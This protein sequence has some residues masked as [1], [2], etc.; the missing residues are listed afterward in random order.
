GS[1]VLKT[2]D[3]NLES[4]LS[5]Y[6]D[7][8]Y[9]TIGLK[10]QVNAFIGSHMSIEVT[11]MNHHVSVSSNVVLERASNQVVTKE[12]IVD[13]ISKLGN[14]PFYFEELIVDTDNL[15]FIPIK[16]MNE[17]RRLAIEEIKAL[18]EF[19][20]RKHL[21]VDQVEDQIEI[22]PSDFELIVKV[23][24]LEQF[25]EAIQAGIRT[26]YYE[27]LLQ[28]E[29]NHIELF[30]VRKRIQQHQSDLIH[31]PTVINEVGSL[32]LNPK[33]YKLVTNEF[34]NVTNIYTAHLL[35]KYHVERV[36][37]SPELS[38]Q[39]VFDFRDRFLQE[40]NYIPNLELVVYGRVDLMISKYCPIAKTFKTKQNCH[41][42]ELNMYYLEDRMKAK[43][44]LINDGNCNIRILNNKP[45]NLIEYVNQIRSSG[46]NKIRLD[47]TTERALE[48]KEVIKSF[49][50]AID[51]EM[52][53]PNPKVITYGRFKD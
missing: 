8:N 41:L 27:D 29:S 51:G 6:L 18:R 4:K 32:M 13:H 50:K 16:V 21:I 53:Y 26:I 12:Q 17:L 30:S 38:N 22:K 2:L 28:I 19:E 31:K 39:R 36:T 47:F 45:L 11:D 48:V 43:F 23:T 14:T 5:I 7:E 1:Q 34:L 46:I 3:S 10:G 49:K 25:N 42:C 20:R 33:G 37:L 9:K 24:T 52:I 40:F 15:S 35:Y 44:P